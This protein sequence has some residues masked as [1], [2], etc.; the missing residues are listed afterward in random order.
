MMGNAKFTTVYKGGSAL[1]EPCSVNESTKEVSGIG[2]SKLGCKRAGAVQ[3][4]YVV[5]NG[6]EHSVGSTPGCGYWKK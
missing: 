3:K 5:I 6:K 2:T 1:T 4:Q